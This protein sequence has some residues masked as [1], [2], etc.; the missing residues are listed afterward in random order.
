MGSNLAAKAGAEALPAQLA[1]AA[2]RRLVI[3]KL[4]P[5]PENYAR[6]YALE[7][8]ETPTESDG[9]ALARL[10]DRLV[11]G[12]ERGGRHWT[13]ARKKESLQRVVGQLMGP[14]KDL[15]VDTLVVLDVAF[16]Q[17]P[18]ELV[19]VTEM[20]EET[21]LGNADL[22]DQFVDRG[23]AKTLRQHRRLRDVED[24]RSRFLTLSH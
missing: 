19:L 1:K 16:K 11:R 21:A 23:R 13:S 22:G 4:E 2:F 20:V 6:A 15:I 12:V 8:G 18:C 9:A 3:D 7:S 24:P 14:A 10:I 5:T 17:R